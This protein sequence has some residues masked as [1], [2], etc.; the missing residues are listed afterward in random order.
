MTLSPLK[1]LLLALVLLGPFLPQVAH[2]QNRAL[3]GRILLASLE[4]A[5]PGQDQPISQH[6]PTAGEL[7]ATETGA[8]Q[9]LC[10]PPAPWFQVDP[11]P[12]ELDQTILHQPD[13]YPFETLLRIRIRA[14][15]RGWQLKIQST[16]LRAQDDSHDIDPIESSEVRI[17]AKN[18]KL[19]PLTDFY[20]LEDRGKAG[21]HFIDV[22]IVL[23]SDQIHDAATYTGRLILAARP[24]NYG[25]WEQIC[26]PVIVHIRSE[27]THSIRCNKIYFHFGRPDQGPLEAEILGELHSDIPLAVT[28]VVADGQVNNLPQLKAFPNSQQTDPTVTVPLDWR[29]GEGTFSSMRPP[30]EVI[31]GGKG[32][33]WNV[34]GLPGCVSYRL[35]CTAKPEAYQAPGD[36]GRAICV[37]VTP[38]L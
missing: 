17:R 37:E 23:V 28:L 12:S 6:L 24:Q 16:G 27:V 19:I 38:R 5:E 31:D 29:F 30:D 36:Y 32:L 25:P 35:K 20:E 15:E 18:N 2:A 21:E 22:E 10:L 34:K 14:I 33:M 3:R 7:P 11:M 1:T 13:T 8:I 26:I 9:P 4:T